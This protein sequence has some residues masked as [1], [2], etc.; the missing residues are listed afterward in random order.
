MRCQVTTISLLALV[1]SA[2]SSG[3]SNAP[4]GEALPP[5]SESASRD[6]RTQDPS[7]NPVSSQTSSAGESQQVM[8]LLSG[9]G[10][11]GGT[12]A[13][14]QTANTVGAGGAT[15]TGAAGAP[16][17]GVAGA[18][19]TGAG[20]ASTIPPTAS[21]GC[22]RAAGIPA[23]VN[24]PN[25][26]VEF[27]PNYNGSTPV[28]LLFAFHGANR[29]NIEMRTEDS[30][31]VDSVL[32]NNYVVAY[33]KSAGNAWDLG[34]DYPRFEAVL[35]Q[36]LRDYCVDTGALFAMGHSSGAQFIAQMLGDNR[37]RETRFAGVVPVSS[38]RFGNPAWDPVPTMLI[39]GMNDTARPNDRSGAVDITQY[40]ES[41]RCSTAMT[42]RA[43]PTCPSLAMGAAVNAGCVEYNGCSA[44]TVFCNHNDPNYLENGQPT[45]HGWPCFANQQIFEFLESVR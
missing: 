18:P 13:G 15:A 36:M 11:G 25:T 14:N 34:T 4:A 30:R 2:C 44:P 9:Q 23:N 12:S 35:D 45:N 1:A 32:E 19:T 29:T 21:A 41:N 42:G 31:S 10:T 8:D 22:G 37:A 17:V 24:V 33:M 38:S 27:P 28:P 7:A 6:S 43:V 5:F 39:H 3:D 20:G 40:T 26:W 16:A